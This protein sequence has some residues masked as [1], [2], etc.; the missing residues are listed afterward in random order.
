LLADTP[1]EL[2]F[3][4]DR[5]E[6][7]EGAARLGWKTIWHRDPQTTTDALRSLMGT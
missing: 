2:V 7:V 1:R 3:I 4:D 5:L 6:N